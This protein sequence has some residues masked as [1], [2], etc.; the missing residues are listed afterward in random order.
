MVQ[1]AAHMPASSEIG[2]D[3]RYIDERPPDL[4]LTLYSS[5]PV[6]YMNMAHSTPFD[7]AKLAY[8]AL[9]ILGRAP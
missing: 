8:N 9:Q 3:L 7:T 4:M 1:P 6:S 2:S 5:T